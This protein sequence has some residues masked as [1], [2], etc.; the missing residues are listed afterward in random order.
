MEKHPMQRVTCPFSLVLSKAIPSTLQY[1]VRGY[2]AWL[3]R[4][5]RS[6]YTVSLLRRVAGRLIASIILLTFSWEDSIGEIFHG[7]TA[8]GIL[9][10]IFPLEG[11]SRGPF[12]GNTAC[13]SLVTATRASCML[14]S[15]R[16]GGGHVQ[17]IAAPPN[18]FFCFPDR[19]GTSAV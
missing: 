6:S 17:A 14:G 19:L 8:R 9:C 3:R 15:L 7:N 18:G 16:T 13:G 10:R 1:G 12:H 2:R 4:S 11:G 5:A